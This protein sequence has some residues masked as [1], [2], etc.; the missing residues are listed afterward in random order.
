MRR[1]VSWSALT[2]VWLILLAGCGGHRSFTVNTGAD[3]SLRDVRTVP[4]DGDYNVS[5]NIWIR[6]YWPT[7]TE[8]PPSFTFSLRNQSDVRVGTSKHSGDEQYEWWF[9]PVSELDHH[10]RY[11]IEIASGADKVTSYFFTEESVA[12][13]ETRSADPG[14]GPR[15]SGF[16]EE[17]TIVR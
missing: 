8:P 9:E 11:K 12:E 10:A 7:G 14:V 4:G 13:T 17:H 15:E 2:I 1:V 16:V 6:V 3:G 5:T